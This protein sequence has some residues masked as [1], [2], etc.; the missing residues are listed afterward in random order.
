MSN[1]EIT[2]DSGTSRQEEYGRFWNHQGFLSGPGFKVWAKDFP[3]GSR[4]IVTARVEL[5]DIS[6]SSMTES[7]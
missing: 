3:A 7:G 2:C 6:S 5:P 4:L 1:L